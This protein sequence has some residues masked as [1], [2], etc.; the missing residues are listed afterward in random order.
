MRGPQLK[1]LYCTVQSLYQLFCFLDIHHLH[2][3]VRATIP[4]ARPWTYSF[5]MRKVALL[6]WPFAC[7]FREDVSGDGNV[8]EPLPQG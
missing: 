3:L 6:F 5:A 1:L 4:V 2:G 8:I 7:S